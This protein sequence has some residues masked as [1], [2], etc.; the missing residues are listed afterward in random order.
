MAKTALIRGPK[1]YARLCTEN[2]FR[3]LGE[4]EFRNEALIARFP[5]LCADVAIFYYEG[6][7]KNKGT[8]GEA[9]RARALELLAQRNLTSSPEIL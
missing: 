1:A 7:P 4:K 2:M 6:L 5:T 8:V 9:A 3:E